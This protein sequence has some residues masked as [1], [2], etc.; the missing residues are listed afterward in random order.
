[1]R[2]LL[3]RRRTV[4]ARL[5]GAGQVARIRTGGG[6]TAD[7]GPVRV[8]DDR[9][10]GGATRRRRLG[11]GGSA[12]GSR[13]CTACGRRRPPAAGACAQDGGRVVAMS[14][15]PASGLEIAVTGM[16]GRFPGAATVD[17]LWRN[18]CAGVESIAAFTDA[19][20]IGAGVDPAL[21]ADPRYVKA[22]AILED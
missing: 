3:R 8:S 21:L 16:A 13:A 10:A 20:M 11:Q 22:G 9:R 2:Q 14:Q 6:G 12:A 15:Q 19:E 18:L 4:A 5:A 7:R 17:A 1:G